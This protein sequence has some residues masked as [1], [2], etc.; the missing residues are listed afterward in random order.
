MKDKKK[1]IAGLLALLILA[2]AIFFLIRAG[3]SHASIIRLSGN[4]EVT[5]AEVSFKIPGR[6]EARL[7]DEGELVKEGQL[8][9]RL[10]SADLVQE[11]ALRKAD[12]QNAQAALDELLAGYRKEDIAQ[13]EAAAQQA[14]S[15]L[16]EMLA[17]SRP[18]EIAASQATV[19]VYLG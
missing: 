3:S 13:G 4:I 8:V 16:E 12:A 18:Q 15:R 2:A 1:L 11:V 10:E 14:Q 6:V 5:D 19:I 17:G 7:V 9:A